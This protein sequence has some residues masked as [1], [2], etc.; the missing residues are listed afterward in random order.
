MKN[1]RCSPLSNT[2][3]YIYVISILHTCSPQCSPT[4]ELPLHA[5]LPLVEHNE[6]KIEESERKRERERERERESEDPNLRIKRETR[7][8]TPTSR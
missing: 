4:P 3:V 5:H 8:R 6:V 7:A 2:P 1:Y